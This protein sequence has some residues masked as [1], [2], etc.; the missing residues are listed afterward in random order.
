[1]TESIYFRNGCIKVKSWVG[2]IN[3][4][5]NLCMIFSMDWWVLFTYQMGS[6]VDLLTINRSYMWL[7]LNKVK[8]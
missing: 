4:L 5:L 7:L 6:P 1:M 8:L 3:Q 2:S